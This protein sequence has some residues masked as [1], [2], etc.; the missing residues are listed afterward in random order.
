MQFTL[1]AYDGVDAEAPARRMAAREAHLDTIAQYQAHGN[2]LLGAA[3]IDGAG[4]MIGSVI[5]ADFPSREAL[6]AWLAE[7]PYVKH[8]VWERVDVIPCR[9]GPSFSHLLKA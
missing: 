5:V 4:H 6:D 9:L 2:M 7:E 1:L 8:K 3:L